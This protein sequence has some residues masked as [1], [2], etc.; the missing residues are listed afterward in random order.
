MNTSIL[1]ILQSGADVTINVKSSDLKDFGRYLIDTATK[2]TKDRIREDE[3]D[4]TNCG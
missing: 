1:E 3:E 2:E 4:F